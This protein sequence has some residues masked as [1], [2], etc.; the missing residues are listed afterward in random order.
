VDNG[1]F[2]AVLNKELSP[3]T[4]IGYDDFD[5]I[6]AVVSDEEDVEPTGTGYRTPLQ[7]TTQNKRASFPVE[8]LNR[9]VEFSLYLT[10]PQNTELNLLNLTCQIHLE[11]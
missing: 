2:Y 3:G 11:V 7:L 1:I 10:V 9:G 4:V 8:K 6:Q 5:G